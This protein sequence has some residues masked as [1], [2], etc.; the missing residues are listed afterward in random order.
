MSLEFKSTKGSCS[1]Y[2]LFY[3]EKFDGCYYLNGKFLGLSLPWLPSAEIFGFNT[4]AFKSFS[5]STNQ[6]H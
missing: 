1:A 4:S 5:V 6:E 2:D 3:D